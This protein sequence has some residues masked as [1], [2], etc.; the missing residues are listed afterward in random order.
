MTTTK[1]HNIFSNLTPIDTIKIQ[2]LVVTFLTVRRWIRVR[3]VR[4]R[5]ASRLS[6]WS[7]CYSSWKD[8]LW[9]VELEIFINK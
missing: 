3:N 7:E 4:I 2:T 5:C 1:I 8:C 9:R 6:E